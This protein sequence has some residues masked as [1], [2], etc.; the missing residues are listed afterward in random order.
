MFKNKKAVYILI[1]LNIAI[2]GYFGYRFYSMYN[3]SDPAIVNENV[4]AITL[5]EMTDSVCYK[6]SLDY[7]DPFLKHSEK[8]KSYYSSNSN[9]TAQ[10]R[11]EKVKVVKTATVAIPPKPRPDI[12]YL[13]LVKNSTSGTA[14]ALVS[15]NG[16][17]K[18]IKANDILEGITFKSFSKDSLIAKSGKETI[19]VRK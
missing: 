1:P 11:I 8:Q 16:Q 14:T 2:W 10:K 3:G 6:L 4:A 12:K 13:G 19:V 17:S 9:V 15:L 7:T 18:L 5:K